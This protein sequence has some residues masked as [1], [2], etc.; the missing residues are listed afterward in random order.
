MT[1]QLPKELLQTPT[2][3]PAFGNAPLSCD[4][5]VLVDLVEELRD[6]AYHFA[7]IT[8]LTQARVNARAN[9][10]R[11]TDLAGVFGWSR[12]FDDCLLPPKILELM[13]AA[14]V[15]A[16]HD[17]GGWRSL[18]RVSTIGTQMFVH[19]SYPTRDADSVFFGPETVRFVD[20]IR[21]HLAANG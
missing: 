9:N 13:R 12:A 8:P 17:S 2:R 19:S 18:V 3:S 20:A 4:D 7:T 1:K 6:C 21:R 11:A 14:K 15:V 10:A 16:P 5:Q